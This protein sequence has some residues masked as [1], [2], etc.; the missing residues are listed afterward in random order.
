MAAARRTVTHASDSVRNKEWDKATG[1]FTGANDNVGNYTINAYVIA[2]NLWSP[3][4]LGLDQTVFYSLVAV[5]IV[6]AVLILSSVILVARRKRIKRLTL[7]SS[8][9]G[10]IV[11][12]NHHY[13]Y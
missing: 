10:K 7:S 3:Q 12:H 2:T 5:I 6:L 13:G 9:Q 11:A 1:V 4:I 8:S